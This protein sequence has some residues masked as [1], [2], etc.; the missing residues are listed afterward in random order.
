ME[1]L[2]SLFSLIKA[3]DRVTIVTR[4]GQKRAGRAVMKNRTY[5]CWVLNM[6][7]KHGTPALATPSNVIK[8]TRP[9][10]TK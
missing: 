8:V 1:Q 5:D 2:P 9:R 3:G 10:N 4:H 7:G 6:G